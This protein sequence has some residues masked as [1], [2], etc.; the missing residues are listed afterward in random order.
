[1]TSQPRA[2]SHDEAIELLPWLLNGS[3]SGARA[4]AVMQHV[5]DCMECRRERKQLE[6]IR[7]DISHDSVARAVP[8]P[9]PSKVLAR[10]DEFEEKQ[11]RNPFVKLGRLVHEHPFLA[12]VAQAAAILVAVA[13][14]IVPGSRE[15]A[16]ETLT[17][18]ESIPAGTYLRVVFEPGMSS[19]SINGILESMNL[20]IVAGPTEHGIYT[21]GVTDEDRVADHATLADQLRSKLDVL[22]SEVIHIGETP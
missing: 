11:M 10:I 4:D 22:F 5:A 7:S 2:I 9:D 12:Y 8:A 6:A 13:L 18:A 3:L 17:Q 14:L 16:F 19:I 21:L 15:P 20:Q 1:M